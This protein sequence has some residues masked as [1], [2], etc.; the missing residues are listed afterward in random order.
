MDIEQII[1]LALKGV[2]TLGVVGTWLYVLVAQG[3]AP[4]SLETAAKIVLGFVFGAIVESIR[5]RVK[6]Q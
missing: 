2:V 5:Q 4:D 6:G 1:T 3:Q